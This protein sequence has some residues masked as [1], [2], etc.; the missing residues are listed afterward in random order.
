[1]LLF[2]D[3]LNMLVRNASPS[4]PMSLR[5]L[6][7]TLSTHVELL[8]LLCVIVVNVIVVVCSSCVF[9]SMCCVFYV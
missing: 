6:M 5:S 9:L 7:L 2:S 4:G 1:M 3:M 8:F